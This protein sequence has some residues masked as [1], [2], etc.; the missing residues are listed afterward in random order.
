MKQIKNLVFKSGGVK[1]IAYAGCI[2]NPPGS[3]S[4]GIDKIIPKNGDNIA[5]NSTIYGDNPIHC[6]LC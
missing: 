1:V 6:L 3:K 4:I 5:L 2:K